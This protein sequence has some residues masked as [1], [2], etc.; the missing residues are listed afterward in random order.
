MSDK[1]QDLESQDTVIRIRRE[2][3]VDLET[4]EEFKSLVDNKI[5]KLVDNKVDKKDIVCYLDCKTGDFLL[6]NDILDIAEDLILLNEE[7]IPIDERL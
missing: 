1:S 3:F 5:N 4:D 2:E 7:F 6:A